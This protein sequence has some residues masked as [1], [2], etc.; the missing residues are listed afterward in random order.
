MIEITTINAKTITPLV[1]K[2]VK[3]YMK[4]SF[5]PMTVMIFELSKRTKEINIE[6]DWIHYSKIARIE[7]DD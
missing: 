1:G 4:N 2:K 3:M 6:S 5:M 7:I